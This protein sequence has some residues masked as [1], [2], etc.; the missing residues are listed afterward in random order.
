MTA[1]LTCGSCGGEP[2]EGARFC[3]A[4]GAPIASSQPAAEYK[5]VT[6]LFADVVRSMDIAAAEGPERLRQ[7][8]AELLDRSTTVVKR[9]EAAILTLAAYPTE[10]RFV[11][12]DIWLLRLRA[13]L[14]HARGD[15]ADYGELRDA[16]RKMATKLGFE[17]HMA[18]AE[19]MP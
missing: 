17:G 14:A 10:P 13:L 8:M 1:A 4:R 19:A 5:Q 2:R 7:M 9:V 3:D 11:L 18:W 6:V 12:H 16:Y 15:D